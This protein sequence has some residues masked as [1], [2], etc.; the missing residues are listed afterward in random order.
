[1]PV[2]S[3]LGVRGV[4]LFVLAWTGEHLVRRGG[5]T[6]PRGLRAILYNVHI[7]SP[8]RVFYTF[9]FPI[10]LI[11]KKQENMTSDQEAMTMRA[12]QVNFYHLSTKMTFLVDALTLSQ[13]AFVKPWIKS[14]SL[15]K[16]FLTNHN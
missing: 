11:P 1:M 13:S 9:P 15:N 5:G 7:T 4:L 3:A 10:F 14:L 16:A 12:N 8:S 2:S 6:A